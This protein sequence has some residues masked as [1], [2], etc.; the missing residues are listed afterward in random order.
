MSEKDWLEVGAGSFHNFEENDTLIGKYVGMRSGV[1]TNNSNAYD[2]EVDSEVVSFWGSTVIDSRMS[3][4]PMGSMIK[5]KY[6]GKQEGKNG[7][8]YKNYA[9]F[10]KPDTNEVEDD[11]KF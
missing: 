5:V 3:Q 9:I 1:G 6:L 7:R 11:I 2:V 4:V 10:Y 8:S